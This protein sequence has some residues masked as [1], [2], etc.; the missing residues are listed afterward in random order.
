MAPAEWGR[1]SHL[2]EWRYQGQYKNETLF[3]EKA[4]RKG[5]DSMG[6]SVVILR[7]VSLIL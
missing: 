5:L 4:H 1:T 2:D 3:Y 6:K 7:T